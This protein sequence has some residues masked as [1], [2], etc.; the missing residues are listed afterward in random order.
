M[1]ILVLLLV[2]VL[3][4]FREWPCRDASLALVRDWVVR[5]LVHRI[6]HPPLRF[7]LWMVVK[8]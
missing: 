5:P 8:A 4:A 1:D 3:E 7:N 2:V 6:F